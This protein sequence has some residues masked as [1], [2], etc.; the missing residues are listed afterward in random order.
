MEE[1]EGRVRHEFAELED[2]RLH[3]VIGGEGPLVV[4]LHGFPEFWYA[5]Q[6]QIVALIDAGYRVVA[7]DMRGYNLSDKPSRISDY[8]VEKLAKDVND[9]VHSLGESETIL[10]GHDWGAAVAWATPMWFPELV[11]QLVICNVPHPHRMSQGLKTLKQLRK[12]WYMFAFQLPLLP[13]RM[14]ARNDYEAVRKSL[15]LAG[16]K[17]FSEKDIALYV[18]AAAQPGA[19]TG[20]VNYYRAA[21]RSK[22]GL[23]WEVI[24]CPT[25]V[26]W[27]QRDSFLGEELS[28]PT[29]K[30]VPNCRMEKIPSAG[31]WVQNE[32]PDRV[33]EL[34]LDFLY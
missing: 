18:A 4:L 2:V 1:L 29:S 10:V 20:S 33:N 21:A 24:H 32:A 6:H 17:A 26:I 13:E 22:A 31:H 23:R 15:S 9:L 8:T 34:L 3:Y 5:W 30:W 25:M 16:K 11:T 19:L 14:L 27:G 28:E 12:S 7:P